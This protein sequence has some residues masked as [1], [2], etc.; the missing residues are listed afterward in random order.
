MHESLL[1]KGFSPE[2]RSLGEEWAERWFGLCRACEKW[3][4]TRLSGILSGITGLPG[5]EI[6]N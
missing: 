5:K 1:T 3:K 4:I 2:K 6:L